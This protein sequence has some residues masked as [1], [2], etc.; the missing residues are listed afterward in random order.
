MQWVQ[1]CEFLSEAANLSERLA[2]RWRAVDP[3]LTA[4]A[5]RFGMPVELVTAV[6][7]VESKFNP[8]A[9][10]KVG[11]AGLMQT[12]PS[13][14]AHLAK[15][16]GL[17]YDP[18]DPEQSAMLGAFYLSRIA[19]MFGGALDLTI[20]AYNAGPGAVKKYNG[21]PPFSETRRF[22]PAVNAAYNAFKATQIRCETGGGGSVPQWRK[23]S[24]PS[25]PSSPSRPRPSK[26]STGSQGGRSGDGL[27][28]AALALVV[29]FVASRGRS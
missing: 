27:G 29:L 20:A 10:S 14:G 9:V 28:L 22:V 8:A 5:E 4:A 23:D 26:P 18:F 16:L 21:I 6:A 1:D 13:T 17:T 11:A 7:F 25:R 19:P 3:Y 15:R 12:M 24:R 2:A